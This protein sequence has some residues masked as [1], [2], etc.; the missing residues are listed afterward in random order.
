MI[1]EEYAENFDPLDFK[2]NP[3]KPG[4]FPYFTLLISAVQSGIFGYYYA[5]EGS[6]IME[7]NRSALY[8]IIEVFQ[9][10]FRN[11]LCSPFLYSPWHRAEF[12]RYFTYQFNH[13][14]IT[15]LAGNL[16]FQLVL[17]TLLEVNTSKIAALLPIIRVIVFDSDF[18]LK[19]LIYFYLS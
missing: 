19:C 14:G 4:N 8:F 3:E 16:F 17:G 13:A 12:W 9:S 6:D 11:T 7:F 18:K 1:K 2:C 15:H 10:Y 5:Q